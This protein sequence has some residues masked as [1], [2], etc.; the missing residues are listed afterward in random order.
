[1]VQTDSPYKTIADLKGVRIPSD[2][3]SG[4]IFHYL[5]SAIL[6]TADLTHDDFKKV[7]VP[8]PWRESTP[9][10]RVA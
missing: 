4:R 1:M 9:L 10:P 6:A 2:Y 5:T 7:P 3:V 8:V